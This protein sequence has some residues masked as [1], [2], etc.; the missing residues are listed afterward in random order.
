MDSQFSIPLVKHPTEVAVVAL[1]VALTH[2]LVGVA[3][4]LLR[5]L[6]PVR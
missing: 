6:R 3:V 1:W 2:R 4:Q 5:V